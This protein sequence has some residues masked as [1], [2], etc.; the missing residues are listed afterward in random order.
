MHLNQTVYMFD[1]RE[2]FQNL[3]KGLGY[4]A[5]QLCTMPLTSPLPELS[6]PANTT[7]SEP[8]D[9]YHLLGDYMPPGE[10]R[11]SSLISESAYMADGQ[12]HIE[13]TGSYGQVTNNYKRKNP[14]NGSTLLHE[15]ALSFYKS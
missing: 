3:T 13:M 7:I 11:L 5:K 14:D 6:G 9:P 12:R 4:P 15:L 2:A 8:R 1:K 10:E